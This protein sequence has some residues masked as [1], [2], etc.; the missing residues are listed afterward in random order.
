[1]N[2]AF[3]GRYARYLWKAA[4]IG[5]LHALVKRDIAYK[6]KG[7]I[8]QLSLPAESERFE[9]S[10]PFWSKHTFQACSLNRSDNSP[11]V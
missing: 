9:L 4:G 3:Y 7:I 2:R 11:F 8:F 1:M 10:L 5:N 6:K